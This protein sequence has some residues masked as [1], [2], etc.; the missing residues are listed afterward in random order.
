MNGLVYAV[1]ERDLR[2]RETEVRGNEGFNRLALG[3]PREA[4]SADGAQHL[5]HLGRTGEGVLVEV[6]AQ[7]VEAAERR[8]IFHHGLHALAWCGRNCKICLNH[9][10]SFSCG[11]VGC[12]S[13]LRAP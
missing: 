12:E 4:A 13:L 7:C 1:G 5:A 9:E 2:R 10:D 6:Q 3:I 11:P 8:V